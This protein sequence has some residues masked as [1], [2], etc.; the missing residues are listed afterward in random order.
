LNNFVQIKSAQA[1]DIDSTPGNDTNQTADEDDE[2]K[3][4]ITPT[5]LIQ[6]PATD[7]AALDASGFGKVYPS[8]ASSIVQFDISSNTTGTYQA[9]VYNYAGAVVRSVSVTLER[10]TNTFSLD[11]SDLPTGQYGITL[12]K[13]KMEKN[14][15]KF[16]VVR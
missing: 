16:V 14:Q 6:D 7:R 5:L 12:P 10:G 2:A 9:Q 4:T 11:V 15:A 3:V 13:V 8:P 1:N